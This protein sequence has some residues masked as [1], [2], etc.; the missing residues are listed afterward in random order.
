M[1]DNRKWKFRQILGHQGPLTKDNPDYNSSSYNVKIKWEN[2]EITHE[3]L[4][5]FAIDDPSMCTK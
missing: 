2:G 4:S 3:P 1:E 5:V